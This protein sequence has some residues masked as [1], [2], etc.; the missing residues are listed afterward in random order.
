MEP[1]EKIKVYD[2]GVT[3]ETNPDSIH[4]MRVGYRTGD[5]WA[6]KLDG[7]EALRL[8]ARHFLECIA[9]GKTPITSAESGCRIVRIMEAATESMAKHGEMVRLEQ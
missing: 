7:A 1:T 4:E 9:E 8:L 3:V 6:P 5:M 2:T